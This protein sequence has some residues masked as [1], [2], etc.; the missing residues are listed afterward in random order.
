MKPKYLTAYNRFRTSN[1]FIETANR[2]I[3]YDESAPRVMPVFT[4]GPEDSEDSHGNKFIS[5]HKL[6]IATKDMTGYTFALEVLG[7]YAHL[8]VLMKHKIIGPHIHSW[9][10]ELKAELDS[11]SIKALE[12]ISKEGGTQTQLSAAKFLI[13][14]EYEKAGAVG[15]PSNKN[16]TNKKE[17][18]ARIMSEETAE[19][20]ERLGITKH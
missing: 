11:K 20:A 8:E 4:L 17:T 7:S 14:R 3:I 6:F 10:N 13:N 9:Q 16:I 19:E 12:T 18:T 2:D 15:K 5:M 1:L